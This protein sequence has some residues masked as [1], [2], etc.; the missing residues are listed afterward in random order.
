MVKAFGIGALAQLAA[1]LTGDL[2]D[3]E[4]VGTIP[5]GTGMVRCP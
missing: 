3:D 1:H 4:V 5:A 2:P